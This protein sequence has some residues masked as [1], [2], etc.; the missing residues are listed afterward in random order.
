MIIIGAIIRS[1]LVNI[2][3]SYSFDNYI[4]SLFVNKIIRK[5]LRKLVEAVAF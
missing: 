5:N 2:A 3:S 1:N 4:P